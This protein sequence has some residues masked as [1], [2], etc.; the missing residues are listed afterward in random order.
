VPPSRLSFCYCFVLAADDSSSSLSV[1]W[2]CTR[3]RAR[4]PFF[5]TIDISSRI[6]SRPILGWALAMHSCL[7]FC[8]SVLAS[9]VSSYPLPLRNPSCYCSPLAAGCYLVFLK[10]AAIVPPCASSASTCWWCS[11]SGDIFVRAALLITII[12]RR[13]IICFTGW[14]NDEET[15]SI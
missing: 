10:G 3:P 1:P 15:D 5:S 7:T 12:R 6:L 2:L 14:C 11:T 13:I 8:C 9:A 4:C